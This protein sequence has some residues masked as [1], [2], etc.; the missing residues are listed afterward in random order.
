MDDPNSS[1]ASLDPY[2]PPIIYLPEIEINAGI[3][4][5][6][7]PWC[8]YVYGVCMSHNIHALKYVI[9]LDNQVFKFSLFG[10]TIVSVFSLPG[11]NGRVTGKREK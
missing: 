9:M 8:M 11:H 5:K 1:T 3:S 10:S 2:Y 4:L 7:S 6:I